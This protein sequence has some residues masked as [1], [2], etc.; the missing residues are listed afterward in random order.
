[1]ITV[2]DGAFFSSPLASASLGDGVTTIGAGAFGFCSALR[3]V[4]MGRSVTAIGVMAFGYCTSLE[5]VYCKG[6]APHLQNRV[7]EELDKTVIYYLPGTTG[8]SAT[9]DGRRAALW[10]PKALIDHAGF[11]GGAG[12]F[13]F[14]ISGTENLIVVVEASETVSNPIWIPVA[15]NVLVGGSSHFTD[16]QAVATS[17]HFRLRSPQ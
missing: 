5:G 14:P 4:T 13:S 8:W 15:T 16:S 11:T 10:N 1:V 9:F 12:Q 17:R 3:N 2:G 7:F 6:N